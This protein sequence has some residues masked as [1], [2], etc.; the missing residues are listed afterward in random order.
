MTENSA[1]ATG[2]KP[3][4]VKLGTV[5]VPQPDVEIKLADD[6]EI[7]VRHPGVFLGYYGTAYLSN[8]RFSQIIK[9]F[10]LD[11]SQVQEKMLNEPY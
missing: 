1:V 3:G 5:G 9:A 11:E 10:G 2:N 6:G 8:Q 4:A 7:L